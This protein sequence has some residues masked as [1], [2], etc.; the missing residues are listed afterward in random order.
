MFARL[1]TSP[2]GF[3]TD[4]VNLL[5]VDE[6]I[7]HARRIGSTTHTGNHD[8]RQFAHLVQTLLAGLAADYRLKFSNHLREWVRTNY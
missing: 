1:G 2:P 5:I 3:H 4:E 8:V 7:E 6:W